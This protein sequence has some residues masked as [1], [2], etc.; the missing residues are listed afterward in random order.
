MEYLVSEQGGGAYKQRRQGAEGNQ[1]LTTGAALWSPLGPVGC[2]CSATS[3]KCQ[4]RGGAT[5]SS[6]WQLAPGASYKVS[7]CVN[8]CTLTPSPGFAD[9]SWELLHEQLVQRKCQ[10][11]GAIMHL[12]L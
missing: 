2:C 9:T 10:V 6:S 11:P 1:Q 7:Q 8:Q 5:T 12:A 3:A 4:L